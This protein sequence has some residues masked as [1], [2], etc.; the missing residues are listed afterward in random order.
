MRNAITSWPLNFNVN[1]LNPRRRGT[2]LRGRC[3]HVSPT[4]CINCLAHADFPM[5][6]GI[7]HQTELLE[8]KNR[9]TIRKG[10]MQ[11]FTFCMKPLKNYLRFI[12]CG[13]Q[14]ASF[15]RKTVF[16]LSLQGS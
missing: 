13:L 16:F 6:R 9:N 14:F 8:R 15:R 1:N 4:F 2:R 3:V 10:F 12:G 11:N 7:F 5:R